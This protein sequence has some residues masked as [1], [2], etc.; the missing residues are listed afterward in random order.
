VE[1]RRTTKRRKNPKG[2]EMG[3]KERKKKSQNTPGL[4]TIN[5]KRQGTGRKRPGE[6]YKDVLREARVLQMG[7]NRKKI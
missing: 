7:I 6:R 4:K 5:A 1:K 3:T 2:R